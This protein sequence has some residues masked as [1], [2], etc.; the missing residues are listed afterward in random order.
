LLSFLFSLSCFAANPKRLLMLGDS[1]TEGYGVAREEAYPAVLEK[2]IHDAGKNW[3]VVNAGISGSTTASGVSRLKW[4]LKTKP[5]L[6]ILALGAND[7]LRG[8]KIEETKKNLAQTIELAQKEKV[9]VVLAGML[10]PPN[11][12]EKYR[13]DFAKMYVDL[14]AKYHLRKI[15]FLL[16]GVAGKRELNQ[17]DGI[18]PNPEGH[19]IVAKNVYQAIKDLL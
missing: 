18:H 7:G 17:A 6:M 3:V 4:Q 19:K 5:D 2:L 1:L 16:E 9:P 10:L 14:A 15:P 8:L 12:G 13:S 11:Y